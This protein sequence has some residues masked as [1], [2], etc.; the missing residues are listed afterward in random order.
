M[1]STSA[2]PTGSSNPNPAHRAQ[3]GSGHFMLTLCQLA[4]PVSIRP[5]QSPQLKLFTFFMSRAR[6]QDGSERLYLHMGYFETLVDAE[7]WVEAVR[8]HYPN[9]FAT[10]A[11]VAFLLPADYSEAPSMPP[12]ASQPAVPQRFDPAPVKDE[13]LT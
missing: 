1:T 9:A 4:A 6:Q 10:L 11:P 7:R 8:R 13:S 2:R 3:A 12:A 5:P